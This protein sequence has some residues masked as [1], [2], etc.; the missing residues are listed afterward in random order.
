MSYYIGIDLG[1][2]S[3]KCALLRE[4]KLYGIS[5]CKT[6]KELSV[7]ET[8]RKLAALVLETVQKC[9]ITMAEVA[10]VG[11][12]SPGII[13]SEKGMVV[14]W[15]NYGWQNVPLSKLVE[16]Q[17]N[18]HV[19]LM[20]DANAA[21]LGEYEYG[22]GKKYNSIV[23]I[24]IGTGIGSGIVFDGKIFEGNQGAGGELGHEV[25][26]FNGEKCSCGRRG[27]FERYASASALIRQT[28]KAMNAHPE[29]ALWNLCD[30]N[31]KNVNGKT[32]FDG[33]RLGDKTAKNV[34]SRYYQ[35][36]AAGITNA[37]NAFRP[38][39]I[40]LG[41]GISAEREKI[42]KPLQAIVNREKMDGNK[43]TPV[44]IVTATL[45]NDAGIYGAAEY[46]R[47]KV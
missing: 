21:A 39:A 20:N 24:T 40:I 18:K 41:G 3:A 42:T 23:M 25:I 6:A 16:S 8:A 27:C 9:G 13:D 11:I 2:M 29:S 47:R 15:T 14:S 31:I 12:G 26:K 46:A 34:L 32:V 1:G 5:R 45:G 19:F 22:A 43:T 44:Q 17:L 36:L 10:A 28:Q 35:Y 7:E 30:G 37:V 38:E 33:M 4:G